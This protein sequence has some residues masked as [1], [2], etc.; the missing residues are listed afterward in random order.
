LTKTYNR[1]NKPSERS[2]PVQKLR[3][4]HGD[5]DRIV[6]DAYGWNDVSEEAAFVPEWTSTGEAAPV[7][8]TWPHDRRDELLVRLLELNRSRA[9]RRR[10]SVWLD[11]G[12]QILAKTSKNSRK[13]LTWIAMR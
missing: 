11:R 4:L 12:R 13:T 10:A 9:G 1:F 3:E 5:L 8:C 2:V 7:R 6:L